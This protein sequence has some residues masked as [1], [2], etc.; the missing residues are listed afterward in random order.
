M[1]TPAFHAPEWN[2]SLEKVIKKEGEQAQSLYWL[3]NRSEAITAKKNDYL[4]IPM[5][6]LSTLTGFLTGGASE[7]IP[8]WVLGGLS[9]LC[10]IL[11]T[12]NTYYK[13][14]QRSEGHRVAATLYLKLFKQIE[15][16][17]A[18]PPA[19]RSDAGSLLKN[20]RDQMSRVSE[21]APRLDDKSIVEYKSRFHD[22]P[23]SKP[24]VANGLEAVQIYSEAPKQFLAARVD[25]DA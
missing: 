9:V 19:Q 12:I 15:V 23:V 18:L 24:L 8:A 20:L 3:H 14:A 17:M 11:G 7:M 2:S 13:F 10:G 5:I 21:T 4:A 22:E 25:V 16:E 6:V 1:E